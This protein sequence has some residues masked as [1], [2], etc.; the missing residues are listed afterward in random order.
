MKPP[1]AKGLR[2]QCPDFSGQMAW[3]DAEVVKFRPSA[4]G[5][6]IVDQKILM[7]RSRFTDLWDFPGGGVEPFESMSEGM[8]REFFEETGVPVQGDRLVNVA[9]GY[10]AMFGR[11]F[12]SLRFYYQCKR[13]SKAESVMQ[14][15]F[16]EVSE[17]HWWA[18]DEVPTQTMH[19]S[20]VDALQ[21][22]IRGEVF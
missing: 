1:S 9:E 17:L 19:P 22:L 11:P 16:G 4:Y 18:L 2:I 10:I 6:L 15:D 3:Y 12:H 21:K 13:S 5:L 7:S 20:D 14:P 8:A